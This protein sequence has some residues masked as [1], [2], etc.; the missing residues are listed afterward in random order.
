MTPTLAPLAIPGGGIMSPPL[1]LPVHERAAAG[2]TGAAPQ[3]VAQ[4][5]QVVAETD[6]GAYVA[7]VEGKLSVGIDFGCVR[8]SRARA[9]RVRKIR[10]IRGARPARTS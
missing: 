7:E 3:V 6:S 5:Q 9:P 8:L 1:Q 4:G 10:A 2:T